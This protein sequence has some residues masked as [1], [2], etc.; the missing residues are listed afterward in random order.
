[1]LRFKLF[2]IKIC[3][4]FSFFALIA[5]VSLIQGTNYFLFALS[6]CLLH[7][8]GHIIMMC[9]FGVAPKCI[10]FYG[11]G[12][13]IT[14]DN[15]RISSFLQDFLILISGITVNFI[16]FAVLFILPQKS[17]S[18]SLFATFNL[19]IAL[20]NLLP[21]KYFDGGRIIDLIISQKAP[22]HM[23]TVKKSIRIASVVMLVFF[24]VFYAVFKGMNISLYL[25]L[26]YVLISEILL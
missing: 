5:L 7:E 14:P 9:L 2:G 17:F 3:F 10:T 11:G 4:S 8:I 1:M 22:K 24:G 18:V 21:F 15:K 19:I 12:I 20:F 23:V 26:I 25:T 13:K 16:I 6:A